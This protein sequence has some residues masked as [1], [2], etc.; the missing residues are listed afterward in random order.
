MAESLKNTFS[1]VKD[2]WEKIDSKKRRFLIFAVIIGII[3]ILGITYVTNRTNYAMLFNNLEIDDA[4]RIV[5][6]LET[7]KIRYKLENGGRTILIDGG[8]VDNYRM[9]LAMQNLLPDSS[10]GF[11]IFDN[12]GLMVTDEDRQIM[13]QRALTGELQRSIVSLDAIN[14]AKVHLVM[15]QKSIFDTEE[16]QGSASIVVDLKPNGKISNSMVQGI[17]SLV[18]GAVNNMPISNIQV[19]DSSGNLLSGFMQ[20]NGTQNVTDV[21]EQYRIARNAFEKEIEEKLNSLLGSAFG[22]DKVEVSVLAELDFNSEESTIIKYSDPVTRSEQISASGEGMEAQDVTGGS[23]DDNISN[24]IEGSGGGVA[25]FSKILNNELT[26]ET[27]NIIKAPGMVEKLTTSILYDGTLSE[28]NRSNIQSIVAAAIGYD[29]DRGDVISVVGVRFNE[30]A[31]EGTV[32]PDLETGT[33]QEG[34]FQLYRSQLIIG[35]SIL[36]A[37]LLFGIILMLVLGAKK[38]KREDRQFQ[39]DIERGIT[40]E[41]AVEGIEDIVVQ[42]D[43]KGK[44]AQKYAQEHPELAAD[45]IKSWV[46]E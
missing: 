39:V 9:E 4:A 25:S 31:E 15:P 36:G 42:P 26:T 29:G 20:E 22:P 21:L 23:L 41:Q 43:H 13:Y 32:F 5:D 8:S 45:L 19:I 44:K 11:E 34:F 17:A 12:T 24:V 1:G 3:L 2:G 14:T 30:T 35:G 7:K 40:V 16:K 6:D 10:T 33:G 28:E 18:S 37:L 38:R 27:T 46:R